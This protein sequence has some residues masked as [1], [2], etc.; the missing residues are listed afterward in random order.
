MFFFFCFGSCFRLGRVLDKKSWIVSRPWIVA[1]QNVWPIP[2]HHI[3]WVRF[4]GELDQ[5][6]RVEGP[7]LKSSQKII[8]SYDI[9]T[10]VTNNLFLYFY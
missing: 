3:V 1:G 9:R 5:V 4:F 6:D 8:Y 10:C 7:I 2:A